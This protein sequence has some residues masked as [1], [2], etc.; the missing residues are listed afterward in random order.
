MIQASRSLPASPLRPAPARRRPVKSFG[1]RVYAA[2]VVLSEGIPASRWPI[3]RED[4]I[5]FLGCYAAGL[6]FF[7]IMLT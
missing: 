1:T 5:F 2:P 3:S 6:A 7:L 4:L